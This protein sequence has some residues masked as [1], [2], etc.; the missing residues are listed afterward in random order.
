DE[1][2]GRIFADARA[3]LLHHLEIDADQVVAAHA[4]LSRHAGG[5]DADVRA[6]DAGIVVDA[7]ITR[8]ETLDR[9]GLSDVQSLALR[10]ALGDVEQND[11]AEFIEA[12]EVGERAADHAGPDE[13]YLVACYVRIFPLIRRQSE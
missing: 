9:R 1:G 4:G 11:V 7:D 8:V 10:R 5:N 13:G 6:L 3:D 2:L 12:D